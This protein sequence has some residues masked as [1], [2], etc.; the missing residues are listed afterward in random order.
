MLKAT[1]GTMKVGLTRFFRHLTRQPNGKVDPLRYVFASV[2][3]SALFLS[4]FHLADRV[5]EV[6]CKA[7]TIN[8]PATGVL[9]FRSST[10]SRAVI[11]RP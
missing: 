5:G 3:G 11:L 1:N 9:T 8:C 6:F 2:L 7:E 4:E 10:I